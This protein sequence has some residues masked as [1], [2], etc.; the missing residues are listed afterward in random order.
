MTNMGSFYHFA[1]KFLIRLTENG[2]DTDDD[3]AANES[4]TPP[5]VAAQLRTMQLF[6]RRV[7]ELIAEGGLT[8]LNALVLVLTWCLTSKRE[9]VR[10][11]ALQLLH[12]I[13]EHLEK[14]QQQPQD[15]TSDDKQVAMWRTYLSKLLKY[16]KEIEMDGGADYVRV[17]CLTRLLSASVTATIVHFLSMPVPKSS[18]SAS[19]S[20]SSSL[21]FYFDEFNSRLILNEFKYCLLELIKDV[22]GE[23]KLAFMETIMTMLVAQLTEASGGSELE[24]LSVRIVHLVVRHF[25]LSATAAAD[26]FSSAQ[27]QQQD[28]KHFD[29]LVGYLNNRND[30]ARATLLIRHLKRTFVHELAKQNGLFFAKLA[31]KQQLEL[32]KCLFDMMMSK[33]ADESQ[34]AAAAGVSWSSAQSCLLALNLS[35]RHFV[36]LLNERATFTV[37][38][39]TTTKPVAHTTTTVSTTT[40]TTSPDTLNTTKEMKKQLMTLTSVTK[41][42]SRSQWQ[43]TRAILE[44]VQSSLVRETSSSNNNNTA[45]ANNNS[46]MEVDDNDHS[47]VVSSKQVRELM[48]F[49]S[50]SES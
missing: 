11:E 27:Q 23:Q 8:M 24:T 43:C 21:F 40:T 15:A 31:D 20:S 5:L 25:V 29:Y 30:E 18:S 9:R 42:M 16:R 26:F 12:T 1:F 32:L 22:A 36:C 49:R 39:V 14:H 37:D 34:G 38:D 47:L 13:S 50:K 19:S 7:G 33:A 2:T 46:Q 3:A 48:H 28:V 4:S 35:P 10:H 6:R 41:H 45:D 44:L 17:K